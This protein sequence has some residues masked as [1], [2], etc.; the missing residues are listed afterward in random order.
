MHRCPCTRLLRCMNAKSD[1]T[2]K[3][4]YRRPFFAQRPGGFF[5]AAVALSAL[6]RHPRGFY[7][8]PSA[9][10][11]LPPNPRRWCPTPIRCGTHANLPSSLS[12][13]PAWRERVKNTRGS[14]M[15]WRDSEDEKISTDIAIRQASWILGS[16]PS[17]TVVDSFDV[18]P[19]VEN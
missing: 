8:S 19:L 3:G 13:Q 16:S 1:N 5:Y 15:K 10:T 7:V 17:M 6:P 4:V 2:R 9:L 18:L 11:G 14:M 12:G